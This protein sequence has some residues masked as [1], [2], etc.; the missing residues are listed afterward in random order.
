MLTASNQAVMPD[1]HL[2]IAFSEKI[3][4]IAA[5]DALEL[6]SIKPKSEIL[7]KLPLHKNCLVVKL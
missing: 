4:Q 3:D 6:M 5:Y 7:Y 2:E 1:S